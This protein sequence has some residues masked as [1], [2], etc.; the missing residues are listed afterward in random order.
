MGRIVN[1]FGAGA[2]AVMA[3]GCA[4]QNSAPPVRQGWESKI[5]DT[6]KNDWAAKQVMARTTPSLP[7]S[8]ARV[9]SW[10]YGTYRSLSFDVSPDLIQT[11]YSDNIFIDKVRWMT[12]G[13]RSA[14]LAG[15]KGFCQRHSN[16][17][18]FKNVSPSV[19]VH[20]DELMDMLRRLTTMVNTTFLPKEDKEIY[21]ESE[22]WNL[23][24]IYAD[25]DDYAA[26][27]RK[28]LL[29]AGFPASALLLTH[30]NA[31]QGGGSHL[32]L[33][34]RTTDGD[35]VLDNLTNDVKRW[36]EMGYMAVHRAVDPRNS[37]DWLTVKDQVREVR[38][39]GMGLRLNR[40]RPKF[41]H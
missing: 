14:A 22:F 21:G 25:C 40:P 5:R 13:R 4:H 31:P 1:L 19:I 24:N 10:M 7:V 18:G 16:Q 41:P 26:M 32:V 2:V 29:D 11:V 39:E 27:K 28:I 9:K 20:S 12:L 33:T 3:A 34:V 15:H 6:I 35:Y 8:S 37:E 38:H 17:C 30:V 36:N 23:P